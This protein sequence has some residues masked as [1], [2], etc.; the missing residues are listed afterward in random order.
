MLLKAIEDKRFYPVGSDREVESDFQL[1]AGTNLDLPDAVARGTFREDLFARINL[2]SYTLPG[3]AER[4]EDIEPNVDYLLSLTPKDIGQ[5]ARF[6]VEAKKQYMS[7]AS[8]VN[9]AWRGNFRDLSASVTRMATLA[10]GGRITEAVVD[11]EIERLK[12]LWAKEA[13]THGAKSS[14]EIDLATYLDE[15][16]IEKLDLFDRVQLEAVIR[17]CKHSRTLSDAGRKLYN[18]SREERSEVN[19]ADRLR[20]YLAR[21]GLSFSAIVD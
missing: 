20:K 4:P 15:A 6:N 21:F 12:W 16:T 11:A 3:L 18:V 1:I 13:K 2:W 9:G 5:Q 17:V 8:S 14:N 10:E 19:D 7:F